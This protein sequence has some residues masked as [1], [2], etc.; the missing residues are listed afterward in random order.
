VRQSN[1]QPK[2]DARSTSIAGGVTLRILP[3]GDSIT[4][5]FRS[6]DGNGYRL[7]LENLLSGN[8]VDF[9]GSLTNGNMADNHNE[10]H[11][12]AT[13]AQIAG[14][15][16]LS[17]PDRP[18]IVLLHAG[19]NDMNNAPPV[20]PTNAPARLGAMID[21]ILAACPDA[22]V[23]VAQIIPASNPTTN[24]LVQAYDAAI[25]SVVQA[26]ASAGKHVLLVD[27]YDALT[28]SDLFDGLHPNDGGYA[29]MAG[30][31]L[32]GIEKA[33]GLGWVRTPVQVPNPVGGGG[34]ACSGNPIWLPQGEIATGLGAMDMTFSTVWSP[35]GQV[36][37]GAGSA[38]QVRFGDIDGDGRDDYLLVY[39]SGAV[40]LYLNTLG[41]GG[42]IVWVLYPQIATGIPDLDG[43][44]VRFADVNGDGRDDYLWLDP[45]GAVT[46]YINTPG[47]EPARPIWVPWGNILPS[48]GGTRDQIRFGDIDGDG[49]D[50]MLQ[51]GGDG[52]VLCYLN[53][54]TGGGL[55]NWYD[56]GIIASGIG[57]DG[58]GVHIADINGDGRDDYLWLYMN[59]TI[60]PYLNIESQTDGQP[61]W[62]PQAII[63]SG[64]GISRDNIT[65]ADLNGDGK[66]DYVFLDD[67]S[68]AVTLWL[69]TGSGRTEETGQ[70]ILFADL[71]G[72]G[73]DEY[74][75]VDEDG[76]VTA[77]LNL[78]GSNPGQPGWLPQG[79]IAN[80]VG[81][82]QH[83]IRFADIN[84]DGRVEYL[85]VDDETGAVTSWANEG[86]PQGNN[87]PDAGK[88]VWASQGTI[89]TGVGVG[90]GVRFA[91]INGDGRS[92]YIWLD[93]NGAATVLINAGGPDLQRPAWVAQGVVAAGV[94][95]VRED[96]RFADINGDGLDDYLWL[97]RL[98]GS[99]QAWINGGL[100]SQGKV[101]WYPR[102]K[103][104][105]GVGTSG[106][107]IA[108]G[109]LNG[110]K[111]AE[112]LEIT[113]STGAV[114]SWFNGCQELTNA[115]GGG[116]P[117]NLSGPNRPA[118]SPIATPLPLGN[119][120]LPPDPNENAPHDEN[121]AI[122]DQACA[123]E[124]GLPFAAYAPIT[125][126]TGP[127]S[128]PTPTYGT[129]T[130]GCQVCVFKAGDPSGAKCTSVSGCATPTLAIVPT[131]TPAHLV[132]VTLQGEIYEDPLEGDSVLVQ[133]MVVN[134][135]ERCADK[136]YTELPVSASGTDNEAAYNVDCGGECCISLSLSFPFQD[137]FPSL[138]FF[139]LN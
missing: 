113:P 37:S 83:Q 79:V 54:P 104:A 49:Y 50:D 6:S 106:Q 26:R 116:G 138:Y 105:N 100:I 108:F 122:L 112:Y 46:A 29:K 72:D 16:T 9:I 101:T 30:V 82:K 125:A 133:H 89:A 71:N 58:Q 53:I 8:P 55:P 5:G 94:G 42:D 80:G 139:G 129:T 95:A 20:D 74:L 39:D 19:T 109:D 124:Y 97:N 61:T 84:G 14:Y 118:S 45:Q 102:G 78:G 62:L 117:I 93:E 135:V 3:L 88:V 132:C 10:G 57:E 111:R 127:G 75:F 48:L 96:V 87:G 99:V 13:I 76:S 23:L 21:A 24:S 123:L 32:T 131:P 137:H 17:L 134:G 119:D 22:A 35:Q 86:S 2:L 121:Q 67:K 31:W 51:I 4:Y 47:T 73:R 120:I 136:G 52:S 18:N 34:V 130:L 25:P 59:G 98:D 38:S 115:L 85:V 64:L 15:A 56:Q 66:A 69:N 65:F 36:A 92:D 28:Q 41:P 44:G 70:G 1:L 63:P 81:A 107:V 91:D 7:D 27:M 90:K 128:P 110:D 114:A 103:I 60:A 40:D 12:G 33:A 68:G 43:A 11:S 77:Y 126:T